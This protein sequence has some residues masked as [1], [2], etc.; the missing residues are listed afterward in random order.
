MT[1]SAYMKQKQR[2]NERID[3][4]ISGII[5]GALVVTFIYIG[6]TGVTI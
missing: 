2:R 4:L 3:E 1:F 6:A 5:I